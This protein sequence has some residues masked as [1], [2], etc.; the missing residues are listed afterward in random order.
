MEVAFATFQLRVTGVPGDT[1]LEL[2]V[3]LLMVGGWLEPPSEE[4]P[5]PQ[6]DTI[7]PVR[8][9]I[10][11]TTRSLGARVEVTFVHPSGEAEVA[12]KV[13]VPAPAS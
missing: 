13:R 8:K 4:E 10:R 9:R 2:A 3:K 6:P 11:A 1:L 5:E 12:P 7:K